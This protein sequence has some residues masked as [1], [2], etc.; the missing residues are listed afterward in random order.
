MSQ[1]QISTGMAFMHAA[2]R[3]INQAVGDR[4][5]SQLLNAAMEIAINGG[6]D[7]NLGDIELLQGLQMATQESAF[8]PFSEH[9]Y[10]MA[11]KAGSSFCELWEKV[12]SWTPLNT[13]TV[14][15][16]GVIIRKAQRVAPGIAVLVS[17]VDT[18]DRMPRFA[19]RQVWWCTS[20]NTVKGTITLSRFKLFGGHGYPF[21]QEGAP[22]TTKRLTHTSWLKF[23][24]SNQGATK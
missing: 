6:M 14:E 5:R 10:S 23:I 17:G 3:G 4:V 13:P 9:Y 19:G 7:F 24:G 2:H 15:H 21:L 8:T 11:A 18:D 16:D 12:F 22:T 1:T 20:I